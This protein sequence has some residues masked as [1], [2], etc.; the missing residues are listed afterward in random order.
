[1]IAADGH[2]VWLRDLVTIVVE[3]G[4]VCR[5]RGLMV[6]ITDR[7]TA[8]AD[9]ERLRQLEADLARVNRVTTLG[10]LTASLAHEVNQPIAAATTD[11]NTCVRWLTR[12]EP[13]LEEARD[14]AKRT[15]KAVTRAADIISRMRA[16]FK[17]SGHAH[18]P[19]EVNDLIADI[20]ALI[21]SEAARH[22]VSVHTDLASNLPPAMGD[23]VELQQVLLNLMMNGIEAMRNVDGL[24]EMTITSQCGDG[25]EVVVDVA[26]TG[27]GL[28]P[29]RDEI[30]N[31]FFT[32]KTEGT[33]MG[34]AISR[35]IIE[36]HAGR[37]W[38]VPNTHGGATFSFT[39]PAVV[40]AR[41]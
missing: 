18:E 34:L 9:R 29:H 5:L 21:N 36:S 39:L 16:L 14:A 13:H 15:V 20:L 32:T 35:S 1:M 33:G 30:F 26:D 22:R 41:T 11:A 38:A 6:D 27:I 8:E 31:A 40:A 19:V 23:R 17:K 4:R 3:H 10:E 28:P 37:L 12:A 24:R 2:I 25:G 7:K